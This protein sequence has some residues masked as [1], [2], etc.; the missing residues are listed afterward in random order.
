MAIALTS[1]PT[2]EPV[3][4]AEVKA[5]L[6][7]DATDTTEDAAITGFITAAREYCETYQGR[8]Y[9][10][11]TRVHQIDR[12]P[13]AIIRLPYPPL[14][15]IT[16]V[17]YVDSSGVTQTLASGDYLVDAVSQ[18]GRIA[19]AYGCSWPSTREQLAAVTI[20]CLCGYGTA[21]DVPRRVKQAILL[22]VGSMWEHRE[23][24]AFMDDDALAAI[25]ALLGPERVI[26][27]M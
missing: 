21:A 6:R 17:V 24:G 23:A 15:S 22:G 8:Q 3:T 18:P 27:E 14:I 11:A 10:S 5:H 19:P 25:H 20:T 7:I 4:L 16:S 12:F 26:L 13:S 1:L 9:L 2:D